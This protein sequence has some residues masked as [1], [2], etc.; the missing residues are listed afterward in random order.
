MQPAWWLA[1]AL[2]AILYFSGLSTAGLLGPDEPRYAS[3]G[4]EMA[5]SGDWITPRLWGQPWFEK[6][7]LLYWMTA[8]AFD[9]GLGED[10]APRVPVALLSVLFL[11]FFHWI[12]SRQFGPRAAAIA[13]LI[14]ATSAAWLGYSFIGATDLPMSAAFSAAMLL[15]LDWLATGD[16]R[17]LPLCAGLLGVAVLAKGLVPLV[18]TLPLLFCARRRWRDLVRWP[19][20]GAFALIALPWYLLCSWRN[21]STFLRTFFWEQHFGRFTT[22]ALAHPQPFWFYLPVLAGAL[23]PW[24]PLLL[25]LAQPSLYKSKEGASDSRRRFLLLWLLFGLLFFSL[26]KNKLPGYLLPL[27]PA[28]A[29]LMGIAF[30]EARRVRW[31]LPAVALCLIVIPAAL[32]IVPRALASGLSRASM[33]KFQWTWLLPVVLALAIGWL[34]RRGRRTAAWIIMASVLAVTVTVLKLVGLP[35]I[36]RAYSARPLWREISARRADVCIAR[37]HRS[38]RYGLNYYSTTPLP[39]CSQSPRLLEIVQDPGSPPDVRA[40][41]RAPSAP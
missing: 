30:A 36:D 1:I 29:A 39:D 3:V 32:P 14:L 31:A 19:V 37:M 21:G 25:L 22:T 26:S 13:T 41:S 38:W 23:L 15:S 9:L 24:T 11:I 12:L 10:L 28:A 8:A 33:T 2:L 35:A 16:R 17:R 20:L 6:P 27:V 40:A 5:R 34:E 7:A 4:R 18:L